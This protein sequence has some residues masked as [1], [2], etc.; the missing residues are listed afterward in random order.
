MAKIQI[1][2]PHKLNQFKF[3]VNYESYSTEY[4]GSN[5]ALHGK[6]AYWAITNTTNLSKDYRI[7]LMLESEIEPGDFI[8]KFRVIIHSLENNYSRVKFLLKEQIEDLEEF[9]RVVSLEVSNMEYRN[10]NNLPF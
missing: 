9:G 5:S 2:N 7:S 10:T 8:D 6:S 3:A 4:I 1:K